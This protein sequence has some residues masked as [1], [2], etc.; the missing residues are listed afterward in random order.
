MQKI[1]VG[2]GR[3]PSPET[4]TAS[5]ATKLNE[6]IERLEKA[7]GPDREMDIAIAIALFGPVFEGPWN[8]SNPENKPNIKSLHVRI[9]GPREG[10]TPLV[11]PPGHETVKRYTSSVDAALTLVP[12]DRAIDF[13]RYSELGDLKTGK[14]CGERHCKA[15]VWANYD[16][17]TEW[18]CESAPTP[19]LAICIAAL[20]ARASRDTQ[21][22]PEA[23]G[24]SQ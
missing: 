20:R 12:S 5:A 2:A 10:S 4:S 6:I 7:T 24:A 21:A 8:C 18:T 13:T 17:L 15:R 19:A 23:Q 9:P 11:G 3:A 1:S 16:G 22:S 14:P